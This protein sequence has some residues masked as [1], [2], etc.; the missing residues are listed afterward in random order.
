MGTSADTGALSDY[1]MFTDPLYALIEDDG[2]S[3]AMSEITGTV[4]Y[5]ST[6]GNDSNDGLTE[7][8]AKKNWTTA[9]N[10]YSSMPA[11][12]G[13]V[14]KRGDIWSADN[15]T[16]TSGYAT[17]TGTAANP[18]IM[19]CYGTGARPKITRMLT[20]AAAWTAGTGG[21]TGLWYCTVTG[22]QIT[23][24]M[25]DDVTQIGGKDKATLLSTP[26]SVFWHD[27]AGTKMY[28]NIDPTGK[29]F[30]WASGDVL[31]AFNANS[32]YFH[33]KHLNFGGTRTGNILCS[34]INTGVEVEYCT[35]GE[36]SYRGMTMG[37]GAKIRYNIVDNK[38]PIT[39]LYSYFDNGFEGITTTNTGN[40][41]R[42]EVSYNLIKNFEHINLACNT[43]GTAGTTYFGVLAHHNI[44]INDA[45][46]YGG[47]FA[48]QYRQNYMEFYA[49]VLIFPTDSQLD[50]NYGHHHHNIFIRP[51]NNWVKS[52][53]TG[54]GLILNITANSEFIGNVIE[55]NIY[56]KPDGAGMMLTDNNVGKV[57]KTIIRGNLFFDCGKEEVVFQGTT[58]ID[59]AFYIRNISG[60]TYH[61][62]DTIIEDN[63]IFNSKGVLDTV[64]I[65]PSEAAINSN[66]YTVVEAEALVDAYRNVLRR[67]LT[68]S[69]S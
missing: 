39:T 50:G 64:V 19:T 61:V 20:N 27:T 30:K 33:I 51:Q 6:D 62:T 9:W 29:V 34:G 56:Y 8:T 13:I 45:T 68:I 42:T 7:L 46:P 48:V 4:H 15:S 57:D 49:N 14:F 52:W 69:P 11:G 21:D 2:W 25:I 16:V 24:I 55:Y 37:S 23:S 60:S 67:N 18:K 58:P 43:T 22:S 1:N 54:Q 3:N 36:N 53:N 47:R 41:D 65:T 63:I 32:T 31:G 26:E 10:L 40:I 66:I 17:I 59:I 5:F 38:R 12:D 35:L 28:I 44:L